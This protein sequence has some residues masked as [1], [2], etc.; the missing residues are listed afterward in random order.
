MK[1]LYAIATLAL[2]S[3]SAQAWQMVERCTFSKFLWQGV[4]DVLPG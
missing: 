4:H 1:I 3:T 2:L